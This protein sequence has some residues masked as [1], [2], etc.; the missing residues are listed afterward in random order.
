MSTGLYNLI[1]ASRKPEAKIFKR[2]ITHEVLPDIRKHGA[3]LTPAKLEEVLL[4]PDTLIQ[5]ATELKKAREERDALSIRNSELTVQ[6]TVMQPKADYFDEL[7]DRNLLSNFRNTAK[8]L[9]V[10]QKE[11]IEYLLSRGYIYRDAKGTLFPYAEK[12][13][14]LFEIKECFNE[15]T[16]WKGLPDTDYAQRT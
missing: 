11:F 10:K 5:L 7:V 1:L 6:N 15:K 2:W 4:N 3:Y 8:A 16:D 9:G 14:G 12:N 13:D